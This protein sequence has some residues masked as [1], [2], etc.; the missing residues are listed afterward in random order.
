VG[1]GE[2]CV[3]LF[4]WEPVDFPCMIVFWPNFHQFEKY[5]FEKILWRIP[6]FFG[7]II[8]LEFIIIILKRQKSSQLRTR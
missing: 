4:W 8:S 3:K 1:A 7:K 2:H 5:F 6:F